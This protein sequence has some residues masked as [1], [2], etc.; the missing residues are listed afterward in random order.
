MARCVALPCLTASFCISFDHDELILGTFDFQDPSG[1][2]PVV[3]FV[4]M[5]RR[6]RR[7]VLASE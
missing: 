4:E 2:V 7:T 5:L 1:N 6:S 3:V